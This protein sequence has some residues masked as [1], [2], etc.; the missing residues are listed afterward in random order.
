MRT[1]ASL[2]RTASLLALLAW[3]LQAIA[4]GSF[5]VKVD[6]PTFCMGK[7]ELG[8]CVTYFGDAQ[9]CQNLEPCDSTEYT[10]YLAPVVNRSLKWCYGMNHLDECKLFVGTEEACAHVSPCRFD[11]ELLDERYETNR[12]MKNHKD[13]YHKP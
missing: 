9:T 10:R 7:N 3:Q 2:L 6:N 8:Q 11:I 4:A 13:V 5:G 1:Q 12:W